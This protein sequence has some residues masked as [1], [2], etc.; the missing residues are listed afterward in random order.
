MNNIEEQLWNYLDGT[1]SAQEQEAIAHLIATDKTYQQK[2]EEILAFNQE[3]EAIELD[4]PPMAFTYKVMEAVR[5]E[6]ASKPLKAAI[7]N[8]IIKGIAAFFLLSIIVLL[9]IALAST[10]WNSGTTNSVQI[11]FNFELPALKSYFSE[12]ALKG[13]LFF[14]VVLALFLFDGYLRRRQIRQA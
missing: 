10:N 13:F 3:L 6:E 12:P 2:Y 8:R 14:D 1:C 5:A 7:D 9:G 11:P 4:A